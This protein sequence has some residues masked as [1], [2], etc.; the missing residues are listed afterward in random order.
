MA[1]Q[2][3]CPSTSRSRVCRCSQAYTALAS[4]MGPT[5]FPATRMTNSS[6]SPVM[7]MCS[8][9]TR[10]SAHVITQAKGRWPFSNKSA[11]R[12]G[13]KSRSWSSAST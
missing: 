13:D 6:P 5:T 3:V 7:K 2:W 1:P 12:S 11:M 4:S 8:G 10:E 9:T